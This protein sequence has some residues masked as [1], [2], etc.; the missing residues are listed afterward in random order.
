MNVVLAKSWSGKAMTFVHI[1]H[2]VSITCIVL[3]FFLK[4]F[5]LVHIFTPFSI[6]PYYVLYNKTPNVLFIFYG[7]YVYTDLF[8]SMII[9][10]IL[11][12]RCF[13]ENRCDM[14][15]FN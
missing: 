9:Y 6:L 12:R 1:V 8:L 14:Y 3:L 11:T 2:I 7:A 4:A 10:H 13:W 5:I 15:R